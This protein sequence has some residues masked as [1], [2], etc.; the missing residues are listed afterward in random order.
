MTLQDLVD[1]DGTAMPRLAKRQGY[2]DGDAYDRYMGRWSIPLAQRFLEF[3]ALET[4][5][6]VLDVGSGTGA[7]TGEIAASTPVSQIVGI[8]PS[9]P[10]VRAARQ[11]FSDP[12]VR[13]EFSAVD[14]LPHA[15]G[16]FDAVLAQLSLQHFDNRRRALA[17]I[18]RVTRPGGIVAACEWEQGP[19]M[20]MFHLL[21]Q[22]LAAVDHRPGLPSSQS[23]YAHQGALL[24]LWST[25][26]IKEV[27][28]R[29]L[30]VPMRFRS[31]ADFWIPLVE[32]PSG[33]MSRVR[34]LAAPAQEA[35]RLWIRQ[36]LLGDETDGPFTLQ[37]RA[38]AVRGRVA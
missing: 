31:F 3:V 6:S 13:F 5:G 37:A 35:F 14:R 38:W 15:D 12:R 27:D 17:E 28:E 10:F 29:S 36:R 8:D 21:S 19:G 18:L 30:V 26:G 20:E 9:M 24:R 22:A 11:R 34:S 32:G 4:Q 23:S 1:L 2:V 33:T 7:L 16:T 25:C